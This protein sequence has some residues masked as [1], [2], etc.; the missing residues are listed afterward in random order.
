MYY[1]YNSVPPPVPPVTRDRQHRQSLNSAFRLKVGIAACSPKAQHPRLVPLQD[2]VGENTCT[3]S[4][5][6]SM[7]ADVLPH[8][9]DVSSLPIAHHVTIKPCLHAASPSPTLPHTSTDFV[10]LTL[11]SIL[12]GRT[13]YVGCKLQCE[14]IVSEARNIAWMEV[15]AI[16]QREES[17][18]V[19]TASP[20]ATFLLEQNTSYEL[21]LPQLLPPSLSSTVTSTSFSPASHLTH[22][23]TF[24]PS[25]DAWLSR[26]HR[27]CFGYRQ[28]I[29]Q[30]VDTMWQTI[31]IAN[32]LSHQHAKLPAEHLSSSHA[33]ATYAPRTFLLH[34]LSGTG[35]SH[36]CRVVA[37]TSGLA[38]FFIHASSL[39]HR[40]EGASET[41]LANLFQ[42]ARQQSKPCIII[43]DEVDTI[44]PR[45]KGVV[46]GGGAGHGEV[47]DG[48]MK[49]DD[50]PWQMGNSRIEWRMCALLKELLRE[51]NGVELAL[52][53]SFSCPLPP[54]IFVF[55]TVTSPSSL[56]L[57]G[58]RQSPYIDEEL[59]LKALTRA[60]RI[61]AIEMKMSSCTFEEELAA[62]CHADQDTQRKI[63]RKI[64]V[65]IASELHGFV[66]A[67]IDGLVRE[68]IMAALTR[69]RSELVGAGKVTDPS[70][71]PSRSVTPSNVIIKPVDYLSVLE[72]FQ[73]A[74]MQQLEF[75]L[76]NAR[77][78]I[79]APTDAVVIAEEKEAVS[80]VEEIEEP[81]SLETLMPY[82]SSM[83][84]ITHVLER[85]HFPFLLPIK[86]PQLYARWHDALGV[87]A[88]RG[89]L[90]YGG[91]GTG[92]TSLAVCLARACGLNAMVVPSTS[93]VS[94]VVGA[95]EQKLAQLFQKARAS[96]PSMLIFDQMEL[97]APA[98]EGM[99]GED[100]ERRDQAREAD[101][102]ER[103]LTV[104]L[105]EMDGIMAEQEREQVYIVATSS[106][107]DLIDPALLRPGRLDLHIHLPPP[108][109]SVRLQI[110]HHAIRNTP[111]MV[112]TDE[113]GK[114]IVP[115]AHSLTWS[116]LDEEMKKQIVQWPWSQCVEHRSAGS[117][118]AVSSS[119]L[120]DT[121][122]QLLSYMTAS[123]SG[124]DLVSLVRESAM[125][126]LRSDLDARVVRSWT[127]LLQST[128]RHMTGSL[129]NQ[130]EH[131]PIGYRNDEFQWTGAA[132]TE[133]SIG[134]ASTT[135]SGLFS[136]KTTEQLVERNISSKVADGLAF[137]SAVDQPAAFT[138]ATSELNPAPFTFS[139]STPFN[140]SSTPSDSDT[141]SFSM[142][143]ADAPPPPARE[144]RSRSKHAPF[145]STG[146]RGDRERAV[147]RGRDHSW[148]I[149]HS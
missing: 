131:H 145:D 75:R 11:P 73:P 95:S 56:D 17:E 63:K 147:E 93:L 87:R 98:R 127:D 22:S 122:L 42:Q 124:A 29:H 36:L 81:F 57:T 90:L 148:L 149:A 59:E 78:A 115:Q 67:D 44:V 12:A 27:R 104:L 20:H 40:Q 68:T 43:I 102:Y 55:F 135:P 31:D 85:L 130:K 142:G 108:D 54:P 125:H 70:Q 58:L 120:R 105:I 119:E 4:D 8:V 89:V 13:V 83:A 39:F 141:P 140:F 92:K 71:Q 48:G 123:F 94:K 77:T 80:S 86:Q 146:R 61:E 114:I 28:L 91:S 139:S 16:Q 116:M 69:S 72:W 37:G 138:A 126:A 76:P 143:S 66:G 50:T 113:E 121:F 134:P 1:I 41:A 136:K 74:N 137:T 2:L 5:S 88:S 117:S 97:V 118:V 9:V 3:R 47:E 49:E 38:Y 107:P 103:I 24:P 106:R 18:C 46:E 79:H 65:R 82:F 110:I 96:A 62:G 128:M 53:P 144:D 7:S 84:G 109:F 133:P 64:F 10:A 52:D 26:I 6:G 25:V 19:E 30:W 132:D 99:Q 129:T 14:P 34:G 51:I 111:I 35:K 45:P 23:S 21:D 32:Q 33:I 101:A 100:G 112:E 15:T 60:E